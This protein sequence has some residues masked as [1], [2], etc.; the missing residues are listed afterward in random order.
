M[1]WEGLLG[2]AGATLW[3]GAPRAAWRHGGAKLYCIAGENRCTIVAVV[4]L[5]G[6]L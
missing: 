1:P 3:W 2:R 5:I 6:E 4:I